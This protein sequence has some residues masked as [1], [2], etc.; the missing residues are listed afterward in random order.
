MFSKIREHWKALG[1]SRWWQWRKLRK[2]KRWKV[3]GKLGEENWKE[4]WATCPELGTIVVGP[5]DPLAS[6]P[7]DKTDFEVRKAFLR[8][9]EETGKMTQAEAA[10]LTEILGF[11]Q[12]VP[13]MTPQNRAYARGMAKEMETFL[14]PAES[15]PSYQPTKKSL[16]LFR[17]QLLDLLE[18]TME[19]SQ[20]DWQVEMDTPTADEPPSEPISRFVCDLCMR[21]IP[22][23]Q[24]LVATS[25]KRTVALCPR[26]QEEGNTLEMCPECKTFYAH[27]WDQDHSFCDRECLETWSQR[28]K[29]ETK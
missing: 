19:M 6:G 27:R 9:L 24:G 5:V 14:K 26:C 16:P 17:K 10:L 29:K 12:N 28:K 15:S 25:V 21:N 3:T 11:L 23:Y 1:I 2:T 7:K 18:T 13:P 22:S 4:I 20:E 8:H